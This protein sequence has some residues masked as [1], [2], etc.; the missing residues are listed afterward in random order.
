MVDANL[1]GLGSA[2]TRSINVEVNLLNE[3]SSSRAAMQVEIQRQMLVLAG[4]CL[5][6]LVLLPAVSTW[7]SNVFEGTNESVKKRDAALRDQKQLAKT[8]AEVT[9]SLDFA[10]MRGNCNKYRNYLFNESHKFLE[11]TP[12]TVRFDS[13][14]IEAMGGELSFKV[15]ANARSAADGRRFVEAAGR[16]RNVSASNQT[17]IR[18]SQVMGDDGVVFD[19][20]K[21][22]KV[23]K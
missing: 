2:K 21:K 14:K 13:L 8:V 18:Q 12:E 4:V 20:L 10:E 3:W 16:G 1:T 7:R 5:A 9:P 15:V 17:A 22:V 6:G 23:G 11:S 19:Y